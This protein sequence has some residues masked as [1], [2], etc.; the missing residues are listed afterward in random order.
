[1]PDSEV[2]TAFKK[3]ASART[4][5]FEEGSAITGTT[6]ASTPAKNIG[7]PELIPAKY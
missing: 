4:L 6:T 5:L 7:A 3:R 1:M 2:A